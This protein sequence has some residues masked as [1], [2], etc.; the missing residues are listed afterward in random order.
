MLMIY[1]E[2]QIKQIISFYRKNTD[3]MGEGKVGDIDYKDS[4]RVHR[5]YVMVI[6]IFKVLE[7]IFQEN[8]LNCREQVRVITSICL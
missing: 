4:D 6:G 7:H 5:N 3:W 8:N 1:K 2:R